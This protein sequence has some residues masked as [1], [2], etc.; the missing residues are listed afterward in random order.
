MPT[1]LRGIAKRARRDKNGRFRDLYRLLNQDNLRDCF[2]QL[3]RRAAP[4][5]DRVAFAEYERD[6]ENNLA[7]GSG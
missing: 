7:S 5:V 6:L 1:S 3:R 2:Y 4:G